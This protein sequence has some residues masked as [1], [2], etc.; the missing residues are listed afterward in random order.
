MSYSIRVISFRQEKM[1]ELPFVTP[2]EA[3]DEIHYPVDGRFY[4]IWPFMCS[5]L[6]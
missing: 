2:I 4:S 6:K 3:R 5:L 1:T